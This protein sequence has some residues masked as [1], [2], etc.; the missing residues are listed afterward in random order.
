[1]GKLNNT[2]TM[3][4][5]LSNGRKYSIQELS[6]IIEVTP[7]MIRVY[8]EDLEKSGIYIDTIRGKY[9]GY[10]LRQGIR[11]PARKFSERDIE[12]LKDISSN[13]NDEFLLDKFKIF[14]DKVVGIYSST[15]EEGFDILS[16]DE[17]VKKY[18]FFS[19][20]IKEKKK[21]KIIY[22]SFN[23]GENERIIHPYNLFL[24]N[25]G[26]GVA[27]FCEVK[28]DLRHFELNRIIKYELLNEKYE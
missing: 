5:I 4:G 11:I 25:N 10:V 23:K 22:Y 27:S 7:R 24:Y 19:R 28:K 21:V 14:S 6:S 16:D 18:N 20:A 1:M 15:F 26:W 13:I 9:G 3:L 12:L 17:S 2:I 8:K